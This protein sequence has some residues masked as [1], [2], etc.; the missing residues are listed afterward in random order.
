M[1]H[2]LIIAVDD[3]EN[4][5]SMCKG[6]AGCAEI[7]VVELLP[8]KLPAHAALDAMFLPLPAA[9]RWGARPLLHKAQILH[10]QP[11]AGT[12]PVGMPPYVIT[13]V[14]M[15]PDDPQDPRFELQLIMTAVL[16][17]VESFNAAHPEAIRV[18]GLWAGHL[19]VDRLEPEQIGKII[20]SVCHKMSSC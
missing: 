4:A 1:R 20:Q 13:G 18:I 10:T 16:D 17:A 3:H 7:T 5:M 6:L 15:A 19:C 8:E 9:E 14:A 12:P 2:Q 11:A